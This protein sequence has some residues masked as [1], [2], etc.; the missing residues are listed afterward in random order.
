MTGRPRRDHGKNPFAL[1]RDWLLMQKE[2][3]VKRLPILK[4]RP[5]SLEEIS[6]RIKGCARCALSGTRHNIVFGEGAPDADIMVIGE[7]PGKQEDLAGRPFCGPSGELLDR[8]LG[9]I[10]LQRRE[11]FITSCVK[12][13]PPGNRT[14]RAD[15]LRACR[16]FLMS[17][18]QAVRPS[19]ILVLGLVAAQALL[20]KKGNMSSFRGRF[21]ELNGVRVAV[22]YHPAYLLRMD[23]TKQQVFKKMAWQD[24]QMLQ[25]ALD[26]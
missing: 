26:R 14:P 15:E 23:G 8:M 25:R 3:G 7:A 18:I 17:Q 6:G 20:G 5:L 12:C 24:L 4:E 1:T 22:T 9:A 21:H 19:F 16:P 11:L 2:L 10:G 13:R